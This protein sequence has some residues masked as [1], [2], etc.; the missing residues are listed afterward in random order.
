MRKRLFISITLIAFLLQGTVPAYAFTKA[1]SDFLKAIKSYK[2]VSLKK[3]KDSELLAIA[4]TMCGDVYYATT[5]AAIYK[6]NHFQA[7]TKAQK[8]LAEKAREFLC[9]KKITVVTEDG[10]VSTVTIYDANTPTIDA[11]TVYGSNPIGNKLSDAAKQP[12][13]PTVM[14]T[15]VQL[16][17]SQI[18]N[19]FKIRVGDHYLCS[20]RITRAGLT[21][22]VRWFYSHPTSA[23]GAPMNEISNQNSPDLFITQDIVNGFSK[24]T[25]DEQYLICKVEVSVNGVPF[26]SGAF[27]QQRFVHN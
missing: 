11:G 23:S 2:L 9:A 21:G 24:D 22:T 20:Y 15:A 26:I 3:N 18:V 6:K 8:A 17:D 5:I 12:A 7:D 1:E 10:D 13:L 14:N 4:R 25:S 27:S 19:N 16:I